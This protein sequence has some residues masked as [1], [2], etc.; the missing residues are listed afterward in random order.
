MSLVMSLN[1]IFSTTS[2]LTAAVAILA[3]AGPTQAHSWVEEMQA[4][5]PNG[6]YTGDYGYPR[7]YVARTDPGFT[8]DSDDYL[9]PPLTSGRT[10]INGD[11]LLCHPSQRTA[12]YSSQYPQLQ[13]TPGGYLAMK[14]LENGHVT[15]PQNQLGKPKAGGT[16]FIYATSK[17]SDT[18]KIADVLDWTTTGSGGDKRGTLIASNSFDDGRCHQINSGTISQ[19]R[20]Q[21]FPDR[22]AGQPTSQVEQW[23]ETDVQIPASIAK[24][25]DSLTLYWVWQWPTAPGGADPTYPDGKD[26]YYTSCADVKIVDKLDSAAPVHT[27]VQQ[28]PQTNAVSDYKSRTALTQSPSVT[29]AGATGSSY[30]GA[31]SSGLASSTAAAPSTSTPAAASSFS[32]SYAPAA[33]PSSLTTSASASAMNSLPYITYSLSYLPTFTTSL[34]P[35]SSSTHLSG[36]R[37]DSAQGSTIASSLSAS[38]AAAGAT[39]TDTVTQYITV[40][41]PA[42]ASSAPAVAALDAV[43]TQTEEDVMTSLVTV[44]AS[45]FS[46]AFTSGIARGTG[47]GRRWSA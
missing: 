4:I 25:G 43:V 29:L 40:S 23:C 1:N 18:E 17:P 24:A 35:A 22:V 19:Q 13:I 42:G 47:V 27:L 46:S 20:Q 3:L 16:V 36:G 11:D 39:V 44:T 33:G 32:T 7:G 5:G 28:D 10:R 8:G 45:S 2:A 6:S 30:G 31:S 12:K 34:I 15:L 26:E 14:Y 38:S 9:L 21:Q 41:T 37:P